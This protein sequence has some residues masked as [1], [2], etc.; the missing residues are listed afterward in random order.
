MAN[1]EEQAPTSR[2]AVRP[3][4]I[5]KTLERLRMSGAPVGEAGVPQPGM[6]AVLANIIVIV[7]ESGAFGN[8]ANLD[9]FI[10]RLAV[11]HPSRFFIVR[12]SEN[13]KGKG[14]ERTIEAEVTARQVVPDSGAPLL[15]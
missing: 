1:A 2:I 14:S 3:A 6:R 7:H 11:A 9:T 10:S 13:G 8:E 5:E 4:D 12:L 15:S